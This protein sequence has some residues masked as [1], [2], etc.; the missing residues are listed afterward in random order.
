MTSQ[1]KEQIAA[2]RRKG[3]TYAKIAEAAGLSINTVKSFCLRNP[4]TDINTELCKNCGAQ[5]SVLEHRRPRQFCSDKCRVAYWRKMHPERTVYSLTCKNC[6]TLFES[7][8]SRQQKYCS[9]SCYVSDRFGK[10]RPANG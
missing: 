9:H 4:L 6:G 8:G 5:I 2:M 10:E 3:C 7:K 1:Q